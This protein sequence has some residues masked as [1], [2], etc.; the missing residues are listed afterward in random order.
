[1]TLLLQMLALW[2]PKMMWINFPWKLLKNKPSLMMFIDL[3]FNLLILSG[4]Q[5]YLL[6]DTLE[7]T[8]RLKEK[9]FL[10]CTV[11]LLLPTKKDIWHWLLK[12]IEKIQN[13]LMEGNSLNILKK[14]LM[15]VTAFCVKDHLDLPSMKA[16]EAFCSKKF[17]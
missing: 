4:F 12:F 3:I 15:R 16:M 6:V 13:S 14:M 2:L 17:H 5:E 1:M 8:L 10:E 9:P 7:F 11:L